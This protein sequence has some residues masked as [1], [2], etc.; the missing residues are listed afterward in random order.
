M[1]RRAAAFRATRDAH[2]SEMAEDYVELI[3]D[4]IRE[5]GEAR[6]TDLADCMGVATATAA[7]VVQRLKSLGLVESRPYRSLFLT[8]QGEV[9]AAES[10]RRH[11]IVF[12]F[13]CALGLDPE[14][15]EIDAEGMEHHAAPDTLELM[16]AKTAEW[17]A[18]RSGS[19]AGSS[20][21]R[22]PGPA[23]AASTRI[24]RT[25]RGT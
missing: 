13:L 8:P 10:R 23:P 16:R 5:R 22:P 9:I 25:V 12:D 21:G 11:R 20:E 3:E 6:L 19:A 1:E 4:L 14:A 15:A 18:A 7:K 2:S 17:T 24:S